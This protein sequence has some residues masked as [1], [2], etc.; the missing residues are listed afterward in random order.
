MLVIGML[1]LRGRKSCAVSCCRVS[2]EF[3]IRSYRE[4]ECRFETHD[5]GTMRSTGDLGIAFG[6]GRSTPRSR[7]TPA[8]RSSV[9]ALPIV[10]VL[11]RLRRCSYSY[12]NPVLP[13]DV[14]V[15]HT[16][17]AT[18]TAYI[19]RFA[20]RPGDYEYEYRFAEYEYDFARSIVARSCVG[21]ATR[22]TK[23]NRFG[24][25]IWS[26]IGS[27]RGRPKSLVDARRPRCPDFHARKFAWS[28]DARSLAVGYPRGV[29]FELPGEAECGFKKHDSGTRMMHASGRPRVFEIEDPSRPPRD[30]RRYA[31]ESTASEV[32]F[33]PDSDSSL[34]TV[35]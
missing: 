26:Q 6:N 7:S 23:T 13:G 4:T 14:A 24:H 10:L 34:F 3:G 12:S 5:S 28:N 27:R 30:H 29:E 22:S 32:G 11:S 25:R 17:L 21:K 15:P 20:R 18:V 35:T 2:W 9:L 33:L 1:D 8:F 16:L 31:T 19:Q